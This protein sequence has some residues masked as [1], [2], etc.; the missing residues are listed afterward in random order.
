M[1]CVFS[2]RAA[3]TGIFKRYIEVSISKAS[4]KRLKIA[5]FG[6]CFLYTNSIDWIDSI[7]IHNIRS[8]EI[9]R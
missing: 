4:S 7:V 2:K 8:N 3:K 5:D 6:E 1:I 9:Q